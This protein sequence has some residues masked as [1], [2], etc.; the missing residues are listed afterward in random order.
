MN[1]ARSGQYTVNL[2]GTGPRSIAILFSER[3]LKVNVLEGS[4]ARSVYPTQASDMANR[5]AR[6]QIFL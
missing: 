1:V 2:S 6:D 3:T 4:R 5:T